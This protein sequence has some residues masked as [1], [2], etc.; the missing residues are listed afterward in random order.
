MALVYRAYAAR[1]KC[2][3]RWPY[4]Q[5]LALTGVF[6]VLYGRMTD[7]TR[8]I[9]ST[10]SEQTEQLGE[11]LGAALR[12]GE[13]IELVSDLGGGKTTLTR[14][15]A[16]GA[17]SADKVASPTFTVSKV[18]DSPKF[19]IHHFDF[20]RLSEAGVVADELAEIAGEPDMVVV[21]EW[22]DVAHHVL[23]ERRLTIRL[24]QTPE[25]NRQIDVSAHESLSYLIEALQ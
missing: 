4:V 5:K 14:G 22:A 7:V 15:L 17:Q 23:P 19:Q 2:L 24:T 16:K 11:R 9:L 12:G 21:V 8:Q 20:Y 25:G 10:S 13:V 6:A 1:P 3:M 18:Y